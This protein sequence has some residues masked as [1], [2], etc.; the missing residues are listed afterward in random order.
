MIDI[1]GVNIKGL[2]CL[3]KYL[4]MQTQLYVANKS[5]TFDAKLIHHVLTV[6]QDSDEPKKNLQGVAIVLL[7]SGLL[8]INEVEKLTIYNVTIKSDPKELR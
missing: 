5:K 3:C 1:Y 8:Q 4:K 7:Y 6:L 2:S